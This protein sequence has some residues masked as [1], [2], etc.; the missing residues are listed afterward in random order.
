MRRLTATFALLLLLLPCT[1]CGITMRLPQDFLHLETD[2]GFQAVTGDDARIWART[3]EANEASLAFWSQAL[4]HDLVAQRGYELI[5]KGA[6]EG[7]RGAEGVWF[8]CAANVRGER[9]GYLIAL[10]VR[11]DEVRVVEFAARAEVFA[12]RVA[13]VREALPSVRW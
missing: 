1:G 12:A 4:E 10:W 6:L 9:V 7:R 13:A 2:D 3:F 5:E 8:E 11:G